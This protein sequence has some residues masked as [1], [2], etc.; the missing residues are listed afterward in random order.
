[1]SCFVKGRFGFVSGK[2][3]FDER[4][5]KFGKWC[6]TLSNTEKHIQMKS[7]K[8]LAVLLAMCISSGLLAQD[9]PTA[10]T[11][12]PA[13]K[14]NSDT[15]RI[16]IG[17]LKV[18][19]VDEHSDKD[20]DSEITIGDD[21]DDSVSKSELT[22]WGGID[23][24]VNILLNPDG[25]SKMEGDNAWLEQDYSKSFSWSINVFETKIRLI[26]DYV[27]IYT[28]A[29]LT[30]NSYGFEKNIIPV[31]LNDSLYGL[32]IPDSLYKFS[33]NKLRAT[34]LRIPLMLEFNTSADPERTFHVAAGVTGGWKI[35]SITKREFNFED[36]GHKNRVKDDFALTPFTLDASARV[37][38]RNFTLFANYG[39]TPL[40]NK[41]KITPE[42]YSMTVGLSII[43]F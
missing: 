43:P 20:E 2:E 18:I 16:K 7:Y 1:M 25:T 35:G 29:G 17:D 12:P 33:K 22:F 14:T 3:F 5:N 34:Y 8:F 37:G 6:V 4:C 9:E 28:G 30:Y 41:N 38:Y 21:G 32:Y 42:V 27:G 13:P 39:L 24:G 11:P 10:P 31:V 23:M 40:F 15:T 36:A 26:K 19:L